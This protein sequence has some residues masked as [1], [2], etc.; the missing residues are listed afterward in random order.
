MI[1]KHNSDKIRFTGRWNIGE[2]AA[3]VSL[4]RFIRVS[5]EDGVH[6]VRVIMKISIDLGYRMRGDNSNMVYWDDS[7]AGYAWLTAKELNFSPIIMGYGC[8]G[9]TKSGAGGIP[10]VALQR[11]SVKRSTNIIRKK[12]T[13]YIS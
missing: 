11:R 7:T 5:A 2:T 9:V 6:S 13:T 3:E 10:P 4:D 1:I 8:L 12:V